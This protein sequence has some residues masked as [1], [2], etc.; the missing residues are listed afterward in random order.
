MKKK[1][2]ENS[3]SANIFNQKRT[4][5]LSPEKIAFSYDD[6]YE[7]LLKLDQ[8]LLVL[9][10]EE[11]LGLCFVEDATKINMHSEKTNE[12]KPTRKI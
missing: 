8:E 11:S 5:S 10:K 7:K 2:L 1:L 3:F 6:L 12:T 4:V 9:K